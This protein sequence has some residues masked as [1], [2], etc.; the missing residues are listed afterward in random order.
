MQES[1]ACRVGILE[2]TFVWFASVFLAVALFSLCFIGNGAIVIFLVTLEFALPVALLVAPAAIALWK[3]AFRRIALFMFFGSL[4]GPVTLAAF[5]LSLQLKGFNPH[6]IW[7]GE[8]PGIGGF[9]AI[10]F[11]SAVSFAATTIYLLLLRYFY[12]QRCSR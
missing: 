6:K 12:S 11:A 3:F 1:G 7:Y 9:S 2:R 10:V 5:F 8:P 4:T